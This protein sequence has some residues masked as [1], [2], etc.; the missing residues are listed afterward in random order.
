MKVS[1]FVC[2]CLCLCTPLLAQKKVFMNKELVEVKSASEASFYRMENGDSLLMFDLD[3]RLLESFSS[4]KNPDD[5]YNGM[6]RAWYRNGQLK[7]QYAIDHNRLT[8]TVRSWY[9]NGQL[10]RQQLYRQDTLL[11]GQCFT[12]AGKEVGCRVFIEQAGFPG[13]QKGLINYLQSTLRYPKKALKANQQGIVLVEFVVGSNGQL[14][15]IAIK[16][17]V[18]KELDE[19]ALRVVKA[20]PN[21][22]P[23]RVEGEPR[24]TYALQPVAFQLQ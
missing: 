11:S 12:V 22:K 10:R 2:V 24:N 6:H 13:G 3:D 21:W 1:L 5:T 8:D 4:H 23:M 15:S 16:K 9:E 20:M 14:L 7:W 17:S 18:S 19:E